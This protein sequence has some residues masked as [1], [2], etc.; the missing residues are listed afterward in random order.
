MTKIP[1]TK[2]RKVVKYFKSIGYVP[3]RQG[4]NHEVFTR[5]GSLDL[6]IPRHTDISP[7]VIRD[8]CDAAGVTPDELLNSI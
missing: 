4:G 1:R 5:A 2:R 3:S 6:Y 8:L 7:G